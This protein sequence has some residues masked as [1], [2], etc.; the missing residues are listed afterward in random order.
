MALSAIGLL[1]LRV[2]LG[3]G[4]AAHGSQ[5][6]F[7]W[8]GGYGIKGTG[9]WLESIGIKP[10]ALFAILT[11]A[12]EMASGIGIAAGFLSPVSA[13]VMILVMLV[14]IF[15]SHIKKGY[16][17]T[18]GGYEYNLLIIAAALALALTGAGPLSID[19][20]LFK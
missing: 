17:G 13:G 6:L 16:W 5:K 2:I 7:G 3:L 8:F 15:T 4:F 14:A 11:G 18:A 10:G 9:G 20:I 19:A 1:V 12:G